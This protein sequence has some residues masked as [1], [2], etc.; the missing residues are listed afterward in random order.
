MHGYNM[1]RSDRDPGHGGELLTMVKSGLSYSRLPNPTSL[2]ALVIKVGLQTR[3]VI[4]V[5]VYHSLRISFDE[6]DY[7]QLMKEYSQDAIILG[8]LDAYS[9]LFAANSTDTRGRALE[10]L[11]EENNLVVLNTGVGTHV[12]SDG[13]TSHLDVAMASSNIAILP[14]WQVGQSI[15]TLYRVTTDQYS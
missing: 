10:E 8:D 2:G 7:R 6:A 3:S 5:N 11:I 15:V 13:S 1:E 12:L 14:E 4:I 9:P